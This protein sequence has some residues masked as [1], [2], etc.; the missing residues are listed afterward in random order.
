VRILKALSVLEDA[1][2][3]I[4]DISANDVFD[5]AYVTENL[6][7]DAKMT[8]DI[9][10][11]TGVAAKVK[12]FISVNTPDSLGDEEFC[13]SLQNVINKESILSLVKEA[14]DGAALS[15]VMAKYEDYFTNAGLS[16]F[17]GMAAYAKYY[18]PRGN[19]ARNVLCGRVAGKSFAATGDF[20]DAFESA[21]L[22]GVIE[23]AEGWSDVS[24][25]IEKN[26]A[27]FGELPSSMSGITVSNV[28]KKIRGMSFS[29]AADCMNEIDRLAKLEKNTLTAPPYGGGG[30]GGS[31]GSPSLSGGQLITVAE[32]STE[33]NNG[34]GKKTFFSDLDAYEWAKPAIEVLAGEG[35]V[36]GVSE[37]V[38]DCAA[39]VKREEFLKMLVLS[40][41]IYDENAESG[42][43]DAKNGWFGPYIGSAQKYGLVNGT[44]GGIFGVGAEI[45]RED[46]A[47][48]CYNFLTAFGVGL[49]VETSGEMFYDDGEIS[50]YAY[51]AVYSLKRAGIINGV[52][53]NNFAPSVTAGRAE[54]AK[55]IYNVFIKTIAAR[56][57]G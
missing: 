46:M 25:V 51:S 42:F 23:V 15:S 45:S 8:G 11:L 44:G 3:G 6:F 49:N 36:N 5:N 35:I 43:S 13:A 12:E 34:G 29:S 53:E 10:D 17:D 31:F 33:E 30:G 16:G 38:F 1:L 47:V 50:E 4:G 28:Y 14:S 21:I 37:G 40:F 2:N 32:P 54:A 52:G 41:D 48:M 20:R 56:E 7:P 19:A 18:I 9:K 39:A 57:E 27:F 55:I 24:E 26:K 22:L